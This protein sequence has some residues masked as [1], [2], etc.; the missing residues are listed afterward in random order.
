MLVLYIYSS[1]KSINHVNM[2]VYFS[3]RRL[4]HSYE[5]LTK[6][7]EAANLKYMPA[8]AAMFCWL[9]LRDL[10]VEVLRSLLYKFGAV[11]MR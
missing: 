3:H 11:E 2:W 10:L 6:A 1:T 5:V 4:K 8:C 9:D 7:F